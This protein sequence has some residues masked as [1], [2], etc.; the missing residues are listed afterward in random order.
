M[1]CL[2]SDLGASLSLLLGLLATAESSSEHPLAAAVLKFTQGNSVMDP[3]L[4]FSDPD[5]DPIFVR[6]LD[7]D[8]DLDPYSL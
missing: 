4:F 1:C 5:S 8:L 2:S 7:T 3:K 6:V